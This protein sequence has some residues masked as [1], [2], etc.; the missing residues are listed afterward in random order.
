MAMLRSAARHAGLGALACCLAMGSAQ[1]APADYDGEWQFVLACGPNAVTRAAGYTMRQEAT[2]AEGR[3]SDTRLL[4]GDRWQQTDR[5]EAEV[6]DGQMRLTVTSQRGNSSWETRLTGT[7]THDWRFAL[8]GGLLLSDGREVRECTATAHM[9]TP[10]PASLAATAGARH[11]ALTQ[12]IQAAETRAGEA[13]QAL[14]TARQAAERAAAQAAQQQ[15]ALTQRI[16]AAEARAGE[17]EQGLAAARQVAERAA[18][19]ATQQQQAL[20]QRA[21][22][23]ETRA[24]QAE[25][26]LG[27]ARQEAERLR[28]EV[29]RAQAAATR[30]AEARGREIATLRERL[31]AAEAALAEARR[32]LEAAGRP[33]ATSQP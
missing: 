8:T 7:A 11:A 9:V 5:W 18:A 15:Q 19:Q 20:T 21:E 23:A 31:Q 27:A 30:E 33:S 22:A 29:A 32:D 4:R 26:G 14:A 28:A 2:L 10:A 25:Q 3:F 1:A 13:E 12:R 24:R 17:A 16:Q 6:V